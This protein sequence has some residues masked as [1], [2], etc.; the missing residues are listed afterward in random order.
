MGLIDTLVLVP[1]KRKIAQ[2]IAVTR[3]PKSLRLRLNSVLCKDLNL[4][5]LSHNRCDVSIDKSRRILVVTIDA[6][7]DRPFSIAGRGT[8]GVYAEITVAS[9]VER[10][11]V[12]R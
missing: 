6:D 7:G 4:E 12:S 2:R 3:T 11:R 9:R 8:G 5:N 1:V 10:R